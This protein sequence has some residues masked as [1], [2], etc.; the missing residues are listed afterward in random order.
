MPRS[1]NKG[2]EK[3]SK[4]NHILYDHVSLS[5]VPHDIVRTKSTESDTTD[6]SHDSNSDKKSWRD[7]LFSDSEDEGESIDEDMYTTRAYRDDAEN[8]F[9]KVKSKKSPTKSGGKSCQN[10]TPAFTQSSSKTDHKDRRRGTGG[11]ETSKKNA[12]CKTKEVDLSVFIR[13]MNAKALKNRHVTRK[14]QRN[15]KII[16]NS[17]W[18]NDSLSVP[19]DS[20]I[21]NRTSL[22]SPG[23]ESS[24]SSHTKPA[25]VQS[26]LPS[27]NIYEN[28]SGSVKTISNKKRPNSGGFGSIMK[29]IGVKGA[30]NNSTRPTVSATTP[31]LVRT[32]RGKTGGTS[33]QFSVPS[34]PHAYDSKLPSVK[35]NTSPFIQKLDTNI[36]RS[37]STFNPAFI[38]QR[39]SALSP[40]PPPILSPTIT[41]PKIN[42][43]DEHTTLEESVTRAIF[44]ALFG[45]DDIGS[46]NHRADFPGNERI[47][48]PPPR[49][50]DSD[51]EEEENDEHCLGP[52]LLHCKDIDVVDEKWLTDLIKSRSNSRS[53]SLDLTRKD[54]D[55]SLPVKPGRDNNHISTHHIVSSRDDI[56]PNVSRLLSPPLQGRDKS[57]SID[58]PSPSVAKSESE[59]LLQRYITPTL[60]TKLVLQ[61]PH[62]DER[63][64]S[65]RLSVLKALYKNCSSLRP[66]ISHALVVAAHSRY[67]R[68]EESRRN[69]R[70]LG[71]EVNEASLALESSNIS[72]FDGKP[73]GNVFSTEHMGQKEEYTGTMV[74]DH[75][76]SVIELTLFIV[77]TECTP[78]SD[79][80]SQSHVRDTRN[81]FDVVVSIVTNVMR[82]YGSRL[83]K[84]SGSVEQPGILRG[85][86]KIIDIFM[87]NKVDSISGKAAADTL[88]NRLVKL[89]PRGNHVQ[90]VAYLK[91]CAHILSQMRP[92]SPDIK[93]P[94]L[95]SSDSLSVALRKLTL[96][97]STVSSTIQLALKRLVSCMSSAH[98]KVA[99]QAIQTVMQLNI[100]HPHFISNPLPWRRTPQMCQDMLNNHEETNAV[101]VVV[102]VLR[103]NRSHWH[104]QV[105]H[106]SEEA[107]DNLLDF[108]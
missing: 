107:L 93:L 100:L 28:K 53:N 12:R 43:D 14:S 68:C 40:P 15:R 8:D 51:E 64:S 54:L 104:P 3:P 70:L 6:D 61:L 78:L 90:E 39:S 4:N 9:I 91:L 45:A 38:S 82:C 32:P 49:W 17:M 35:V 69:A 37:P 77:I 98:F 66:I 60:I 108:L 106:L 71:S 59:S 57:N 89:W 5:S 10:G 65:P 26:K 83:G 1:K 95:G 31:R 42:N 80:T 56:S 21:V 36:L 52:E 22:A 7:C 88:L 62:D 34:I 85:V 86:F 25:S 84:S 94:S 74:R 67:L 63:L 58:L 73:R 24:Q 55:F 75:D 99:S 92:P 103:D 46:G 18:H 50:D 13:S 19:Q 87:T 33:P 48:I 96:E 47:P 97:K 44:Q 81:H 30:Q 102:E 41:K 23:S 20:G 16:E 29:N 72:G 105:R 101:E 2:R 27:Q 11:D 76:S 79:S